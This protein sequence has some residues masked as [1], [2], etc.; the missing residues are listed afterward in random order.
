MFDC[1]NSK[2]R[3]SKKEKSRDCSASVGT[4]ATSV[5]RSRYEP[6]RRCIEGDVICD[7]IDTLRYSGRTNLNDDRR[8]TRI[9]DYIDNKRY[10]GYKSS[11]KQRT[12]KSECPILRFDGGSSKSA[13]A[14]GPIFDFG[15]STANAPEPKVHCNSDDVSPGNKVVLD[16]GMAGPSMC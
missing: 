4:S 3:S 5:S 11:E 2:A 15:S 10:S 12:P 16:G 9:L 8:H 6:S 13:Y 14:S 1:G 7:L